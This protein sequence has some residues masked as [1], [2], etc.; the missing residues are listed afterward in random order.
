MSKA[1]KVRIPD[2][3]A[4]RKFYIPANYVETYVSLGYDIFV[5]ETVAIDVT[6]EFLEQVTRDMT[7]GIF[8]EYYASKDGVSFQIPAI[9]IPV[10][11]SRGYDILRS[12]EKLLEDPWAEINTIN[13]S[14]AVE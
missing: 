11:S 13:L 14:S 3:S 7:N 4:Y 12:C 1:Y 9:K 5:E 6:P 8:N 2:G 10:F